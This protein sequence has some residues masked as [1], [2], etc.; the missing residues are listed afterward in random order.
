VYP[1]ALRV[2]NNSAPRVVGA[3]LVAH[4]CHDS[5]LAEQ[6]GGL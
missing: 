5:D 6:D 3:V 1:I 2:P 4:D